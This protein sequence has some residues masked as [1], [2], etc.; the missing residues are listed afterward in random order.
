MIGNLPRD[1]DIHRHLREKQGEK[2]AKKSAKWKHERE[3]KRRKLYI[4][5]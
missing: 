3:G 4:E 1:R 2:Q 5:T